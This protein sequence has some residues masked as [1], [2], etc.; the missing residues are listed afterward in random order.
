MKSTSAAFCLSLCLWAC[1]YVA[2]VD[3]ANSAAS[4]Q[5]A[6][7]VVPDK[8]SG[9]KPVFR[10][11][12]SGDLIMNG[13]VVGFTTYTSSGGASLTLIYNTFPDKPAATSMFDKEIARSLKV[14]EQV[15]KK[16][17]DGKVIG[18]R[19]QIVIP[20][21]AKDKTLSAV[22]WTDGRTFRE[23]QSAGSR[24]VLEFEKIYTYQN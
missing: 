14:I 1:P 19:A 6:S 23:I 16:D 10:R 22:I 21:G 5:S 7:L 4:T 9:K 17:G 15:P 3:Y 11:G 12:M 18:E 24:D 13:T 8:Q 20:S 2:I